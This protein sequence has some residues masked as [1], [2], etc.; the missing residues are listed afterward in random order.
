MLY[1]PKIG[2]SCFPRRKYMQRF[3]RKWRCLSLVCAS[4]VALLGAVACRGANTDTPFSI[5]NQRPQQGSGA[6]ITPQT[7]DHI[8]P[9]WSYQ[10]G[11]T[12]FEEITSTKGVVYVSYP[13]NTSIVGPGE[14]L[15]NFDQTERGGTVSVLDALDSQSGRRLW[16]FQAPE[17]L[18]NTAGPLVVEG[19][20]YLA[21]TY[22][23]C[24]LNG[25]TGKL[26]WCSAL[27][28]HKNDAEYILDGE[29][30]YENGLLFLGAYHTLIAVDATTGNRVWSAPAL[31]RSSHLMAGNHLVYVSAVGGKLAA[32]DARSGRQVWHIALMPDAYDPDDPSGNYAPVPLLG[33]GVLYIL[34]GRLLVAFQGRSG[35]L[36]W[37][38]QVTLDG[39][40]Q[41]EEPP[42]PVVEHVGGTAYVVALVDTA[43]S[44]QVTSE[45]VTYNLHTHKQAWREQ[46]KGA[47]PQALGVS[48]GVVYAASLQSGGPWSPQPRWHFWLSMVDIRSGQLLRQLQNNDSSFRVDQLV[49][50]EGRL[51]VSGDF[52]D[53]GRWM[54]YAL[55]N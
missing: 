23:V 50:S 1:S 55:G 10:P 44:S 45:L 41:L 53:V 32:F 36:L 31:M 11:A 29:M 47:F 13:S 34:T 7:A 54:V 43:R 39:E 8:H 25:Q 49:G 28:D 37:Q 35:G 16:R 30:A 6:A 12:V 27:V 42:F 19:T 52:P 22:H 2:P 4:V 15:G 3:L 14:S 9:L 46:L 26:R 18:D 21:L 17:D 33:D 5:F 40:Y 51:Y 24:A 38:V 20:V 48:S